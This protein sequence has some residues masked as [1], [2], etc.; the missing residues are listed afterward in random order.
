MFD[1]EQWRR[2]YF[3]G[4]YGFVQQAWKK[5]KFFVSRTPQQNG[6]V[7]RKNMTVRE[8][9]QT[10]LIDSKL[11]YIFCSYV[12]HTTFHIKKKVMLRNNSDKTPYLIWKGRPRN[13]KNFIDLGSKC[14]IKREFGRMGKFDSHVDSEILVGYS[15][16]RK[17]YKCYN[18]RIKKVV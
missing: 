11:T 3:K 8:M 4:I 15:S 6:V 13:V 9:A 10:M 1:I 7:E 16:T 17:S 2:F 5:K 18:M 12:V 14:Y